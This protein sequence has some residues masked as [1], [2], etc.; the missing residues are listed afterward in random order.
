MSELSIS[1]RY[2]IFNK[3]IKPTLQKI[4]KRRDGYTKYILKFHGWEK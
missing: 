1:E 2:Y 3:Y 4:I